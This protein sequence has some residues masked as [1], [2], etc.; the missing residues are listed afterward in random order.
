MPTPDAIVQ[1]TTINFQ[2][3]AIC[4]RQS[5]IRLIRASN[6]VTINKTDTVRILQQFNEKAFYSDNQAVSGGSVLIEDTVHQ[7]R[8]IS[9]KLTTNIPVTTITNT[10]TLKE[11]RNV[12]YFGVGAIG[13]QQSLSVGGDLSLKTRNDNMYTAGAFISTNGGLQYQIMYRV[14]IRLKKRKP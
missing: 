10:I 6:A 8:I 13:N 3:A 2:P 12:V 4:S 1:R 11:N 9:R 5:S 7:N 14:P